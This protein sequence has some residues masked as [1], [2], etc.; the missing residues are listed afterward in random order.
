MNQILN[1]IGKFWFPALCIIA[2]T[3]LLVTGFFSGEDVRQSDLALAGTL[4]ILF[5]GILSAL[6]LLD[7][8]PRVAVLVLAVVFS[9]GAIFFAVKNVETVDKELKYITK[10]NLIKSQMIQRMKDVR[11][12][13]LAYLDVHGTYTS[14]WDEL[15]NFVKN[16]KIST[17]KRIG[18]LPD[19]INGGISEA[20]ALGLVQSRPPGMTDEQIK[21]KGIIV[22]D[23]IYESAQKVLFESA[24]SMAK[25]KHPLNIDQFQIAPGTEDVVLR[26]QA[27]SISVS[28]GVMRPV[29][30]C[31]DTKPFTK[32]TMRVGSLSEAITNGNWKE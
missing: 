24:K 4:A 2:G 19:S 11:T 8:L 23:T 25:R 32:D 12:A 17:V 18:S 14:S 27:D 10:K 30:L 29:F 21:S 6:F 16:G 3:F 9:G 26:L 31:E 1:T 28:G 20:M 5:I 15:K 7:I 22:L 13:E